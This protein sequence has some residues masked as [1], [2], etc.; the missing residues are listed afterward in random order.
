MFN[1]FP[2]DLLYLLSVQID[3]LPSL[4]AQTGCPA[5]WNMALA[6]KWPA[7]PTPKGARQGFNLRAC[8]AQFRFV[9]LPNTQI[10]HR[11]SSFT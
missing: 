4:P 9:T 5:P 10:G 1:R 6:A 11:K 3:K 2:G 7:A 8:P